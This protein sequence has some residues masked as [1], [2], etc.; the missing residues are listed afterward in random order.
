MNNTPNISIKYSIRICKYIKQKA[1]KNK[2]LFIIIDL[3]EKYKQ[4]LNKLI[5][6]HNQLLDKFLDLY[7]KF[8]NLIEHI[9]QSSSVIFKTSSIIFKTSNNIDRFNIQE[10]RNKSKEKIEIEHFDKD[11]INYLS[12]HD[13][14]LLFDYIQDRDTD[15][16]DKINR[17]IKLI[18]KLEKMTTDFKHSIITL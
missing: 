8:M 6:N 18:E 5:D 17:I 3:D 13:R 1:Q 14:Q 12:A 15:L 16:H 7:N 10:I 4:T 2:K 9:T 11:I